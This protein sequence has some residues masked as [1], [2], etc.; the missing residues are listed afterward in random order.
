[1]EIS[2]LLKVY[3]SKNI[4]N[5]VMKYFS[6]LNLTKSEHLLDNIETENYIN[7]K[8]L[9]KKKSNYKILN[10]AMNESFINGNKNIIR[11]L[12]YKYNKLNTDPYK[13]FKGDFNWKYTLYSYDYDYDDNELSWNLT[14]ENINIIR[15]MI[16]EGFP[17]DSLN[18][19]ESLHV[20]YEMKCNDSHRLLIKE[21]NKLSEEQLEKLYEQN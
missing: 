12:H 8:K 3:I 2:V 7:I 11:Y 20:S 15:T 4:S 13:S 6:Y 5:V 9:M 18:I 16:C 21:I 14:D 1:M 19:M 10:E 17:S